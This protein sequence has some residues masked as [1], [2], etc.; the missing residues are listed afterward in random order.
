M[1]APLSDGLNARGEAAENLIAGPPVETLQAQQRHQGRQLLAVHAD[2]GQV[3][4]SAGIEQLADDL[5][6]PYGRAEHQVRLGPL[7]EYPRAVPVLGRARAPPARAPRIGPPRLGAGNLLNA[8]VH[9]PG[10]GKVVLVDEPLALSQA[11]VGEANL[12]GVVAEARPA[13]VGDAVL[14]AA[15][16]EPVQVLAAPAERGLHDGVQPGDRGAGGHF[17]SPPDQ[18][19]DPGDHHPQPVNVHAGAR[20]GVSHHAILA[21]PSSGRAV[22]DD[23]GTGRDR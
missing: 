8:Q 20:R 11:Q 15:D 7:Q 17:Q 5:R 23:A 12:P 10:S 22:Y 16:D 2:V 18:R 3:A 9:V 14:G 6:G 4:M 13:E 21:R 1:S 19:A